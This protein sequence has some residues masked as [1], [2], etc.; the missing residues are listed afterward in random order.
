[1]FNIDVQRSL[2]S[3][4][5]LWLSSKELQEIQN[6]H[7]FLTILEGER[8]LEADDYIRR[9]HPFMIRRLGN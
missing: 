1:M 6:S 7:D 3:E 5:P 4:C 8:I 2:S 9:S